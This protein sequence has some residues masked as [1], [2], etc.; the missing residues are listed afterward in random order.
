MVLNHQVEIRSPEDT[1]LVLITGQVERLIRSAS[2]A[3]A[4]AHLYVQGSGVALISLDCPEGNLQSAYDVIA[5][6]RRLSDHPDFL[7]SLFGN[8]L[9]FAVQR[10]QLQ[11][12]TWQEIFLVEFTG[13]SRWH[14]LH[15]QIMGGGT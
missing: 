3:N 4:L 13:R 6:A 5:E 11:L 14:Q 2:Q 10:Q 12:A 9:S 15:V 7:S 8:T 1:P